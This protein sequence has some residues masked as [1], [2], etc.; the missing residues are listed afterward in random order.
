MSI[1]INQT[2]IQKTRIFS[3][4]VSILIML[5]IF[6]F[7]S[8]NGETSQGV[9]DSVLGTLLD[10]LPFDL[11][12]LSGVLNH[13]M[14][15][16]LIRKTAHFSEYALLGFFLMRFISTYPIKGW[17]PIAWGVAT[18]YAGTDELHQFF[19][20]GRSARISDVMI[21]SCGALFGVLLAWWI[22]SR[23]HRK[24]TEE[25]DTKNRKNL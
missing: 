11:S 9:S 7:S 8:Q 15:S 17:I 23:K 3:A 10:M 16:F 5:G 18:F 24:K 1:D 21:D 2:K 14:L 25:K 6:V 20:S 19:I 12:G 4:A 13:D 22:V